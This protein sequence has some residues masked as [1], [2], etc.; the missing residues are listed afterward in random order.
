MITF[1]SNVLRPPVQ[2]TR[3]VL[4][5]SPTRSS[6]SRAETSFFADAFVSLPST[7]KKFN[8]QLPRRECKL[9]GILAD[10]VSYLKDGAETRVL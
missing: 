3:N 1:Q 10:R 2:L 9:I 4:L 7:S 5:A 8:G 6:D